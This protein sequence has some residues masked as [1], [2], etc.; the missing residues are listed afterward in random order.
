MDYLNLIGRSKISHLRHAPQLRYALQTVKR[1]TNTPLDYRHFPDSEAW[2]GKLD[3]YF[4][5]CL[6]G[7][8]VQ[9]PSMHWHKMGIMCF[10][11]LLMFSLYDLPSSFK[12]KSLQNEVIV[13]NNRQC[14]V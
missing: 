10:H 14:N 7:R 6:E 1:A 12:N 8:L 3:L 13:A 9:V 5:T 2:A 4:Q 11:I